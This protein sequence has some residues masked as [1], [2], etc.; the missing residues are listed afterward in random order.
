MPLELSSRLRGYCRWMPSLDACDLRYDRKVDSLISQMRFL[1]F[2]FPKSDLSSQTGFIFTCISLLLLNFSW[3]APDR[4]EPGAEEGR[5]E[6]MIPYFNLLGHE[7]MMVPP[8]QW[9]I[10]WSMRG[11]LYFCI[12]WVGGDGEST[13]IL[14]I[15]GNTDEFRAGHT[16]LWRR[17]A[18]SL[19]KIFP[20]NSYPLVPVLP[21]GAPLTSAWYHLWPLC[22][23]SLHLRRSFSD[24][25]LAI[26]LPTG[27]AIHEA[28]GMCPP[29]PLHIPHLDYAH[30]TP[31]PWNGFPNWA[32][33]QGPCWP[34]LRVCL[35]EDGLYRQWLHPG[36]W[37]VAVWKMGWGSSRG[38]GL[39]VGV[40]TA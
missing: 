22:P 9:G 2:Q 31:G 6:E 38:Q 35:P 32:H 26:P 28:K 17:E 19:G 34:L 23:Q 5:A 13:D 4:D 20:S 18:S 16:N 36:F 15:I 3:R 40:S 12:D 1:F 39:W 10:S 27:W 30:G 33:L 21:F 7:K 14:C 37:E 29:E 8:T 11:R 24:P 25:L